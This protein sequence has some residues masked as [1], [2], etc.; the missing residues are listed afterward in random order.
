[1]IVWTLVWTSVCLDIVLG[2]FTVSIFFKRSG[3]SIS[4]TSALIDVIVAALARIGT[5]VAHVHGAV[6][7]GQSVPRAMHD[8]NNIIRYIFVHA[9]AH[10]GRR[11]RARESMGW[12]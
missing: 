3:L 12:A 1:M 6:G 8:D 9:Y 2:R 10:L 11:S 7:A 4:A 5:Q